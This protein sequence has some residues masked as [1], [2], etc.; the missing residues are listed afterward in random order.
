MDSHKLLVRGVFLNGTSSK[1]EDT[2]NTGGRNNGFCW[3]R[4]IKEYGLSI[5]GR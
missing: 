4:T 3:I 1:P 2:G 5:W